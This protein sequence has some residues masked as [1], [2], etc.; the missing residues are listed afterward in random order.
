MA[1]SKDGEIYKPPISAVFFKHVLLLPKKSFFF[2]FTKINVIFFFNF[3]NLLIHIF[4]IRY[5]LQP[6]IT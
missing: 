5:N 4:R 3:V 1:A 2:I 6:H